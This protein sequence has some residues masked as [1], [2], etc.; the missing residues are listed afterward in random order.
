[1]EN[2]ADKSAPF[3]LLEPETHF[4]AADHK[5]SY[6]HYPENEPARGE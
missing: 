1:M 4:P 6:S 2:G 3:I 5:K